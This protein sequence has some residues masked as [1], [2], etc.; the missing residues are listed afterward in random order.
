MTDN[1]DVV[2]DVDSALA[3]GARIKMSLSQLNPT[4]RRIAEWLIT[5]G[6][7]CQKT[8]LREVAS[9]LEVSEPLLVKVAKKIGFSGFRE[10]RSALLSYFEALPYEREEEITEHDNLDTV[11]D[12]VF[13]NSIQVLKEARSVADSA[14]IGE[15]A[16]FI[17]KARRVIIFGVGGSASVSMDFEH[18]LLRIGIICHTYSDFHLMLMVASQLDEND[19]VIAISQTGDTREILEAV[20]TARLRKA[21]IICITNDDGSPLSQCSDLSIFSPAM[22]GPLLGQNAVARIVQLNLLDSLF[23][24]ILLEDYQGNK[25]KLSRGIDIVSPLH[26][27]K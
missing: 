4:E 9:A 1:Q 15:A 18:K 27:V 25:E 5:K 24:G 23:I 10:L 2:R 19:V 6:N 20:N 12:K 22:S 14:T 11:L 21:K 17:F 13:S 3:I 8:G 7:I 26:G 16:R